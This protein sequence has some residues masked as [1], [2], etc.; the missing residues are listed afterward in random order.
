MEV[1]CNQN[2]CILIDFFDSFESKSNKKWRSTFL[3]NENVHIHTQN[4]Q[5][6]ASEKKSKKKNENTWPYAMLDTVLE[7]D[8]GDRNDF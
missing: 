7:K 8:T 2:S 5:K 3:F 1:R 6:I 4:K